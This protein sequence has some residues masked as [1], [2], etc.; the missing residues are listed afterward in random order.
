MNS[1]FKWAD[2]IRGVR[3]GSSS[4]VS[5]EVRDKSSWFKTFPQFTSRPAGPSPFPVDCGSLL[6]SHSGPEQTESTAL[7][8]D[9]LYHQH[10]ASVW[11][12][13]KHTHKSYNLLSMLAFSCNPAMKSTYI[14]VFLPSGN[15]TPQELKM[16]N[17]VEKLT[18]E[19]WIIQSDLHNAWTSHLNIMYITLLNSCFFNDKSGYILCFSYCW[20]TTLFCNFFLWFIVCIFILYVLL[21]SC[22]PAAINPH[23]NS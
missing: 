20:K 11:N 16:D 10:S 8:P 2:V 1:S 17:G 9:P 19:L 21:S 12:V 14:L 4:T 3:A 22:T 7:P 13:Q 6:S 23:F 15:V 18:T 5:L